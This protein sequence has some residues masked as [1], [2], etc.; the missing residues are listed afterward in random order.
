MGYVHFHTS[1]HCPPRGR[2]C[3]PKGPQPHNRC[4]RAPCRFCTTPHHRTPRRFR[5]TTRVHDESNASATVATSITSTA[6]ST[7][8][9]FAGGGL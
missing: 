6:P 2:L 4:A 7:A 3:R 5:L 8:I 1:A 9:C